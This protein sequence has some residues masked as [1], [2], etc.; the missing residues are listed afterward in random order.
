MNLYIIT[1]FSLLVSFLIL[2]ALVSPKIDKDHNP[3]SISYKV[4][5]A[6]F[7]A[8]LHT[9]NSHYKQLDQF[10]IFMTTFGRELVWAA[11]GIL[12]FV[13]GGVAGRKVIMV[14]AIV[15][16]VLIPLGVFSKGVI[17]RPRPII[18]DE[19]FLISPD[20][21]LAF[22]S[23]HA[24]I[25]SAG[26]ATLLAL[27]R[28]TQKRLVIS[29]ALTVEAAIVCFSRVYVGGHYPLDVVGGILLGVAV[30]FLF[31]PTATYVDKFLQVVSRALKS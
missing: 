25:V 1:S 22:P 27:F 12:L 14:M 16:L 13:F 10:M 17:G 3:N 24:I 18:P 28:N 5:S 30:A 19:D 31:V 11:A 4:T 20:K 21:E 26:S 2:A 23:G 9:N 8:F 15:M 7:Q 29:T 6:D